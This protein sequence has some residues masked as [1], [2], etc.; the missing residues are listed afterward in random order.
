MRAQP[1]IS[2]V[3]ATLNEGPR[4]EST[5][6][7][8][9]STLPPGSDIVVVDDG[10]ADNSLAFL[11]RSPQGVKRISLEHAGAPRARNAGAAHAAG[12]ILVFSDA[13]MSFPRGWWEP[14]V[15][16][17]EN[18]S[19]AAAAPAVADI[20]DSSCIGYGMSL[21]APDLTAN[22]LL[23]AASRP[24][25]VPI[26]PGACWAMRREVF[27]RTGGF[28]EGILRWGSEDVEFS[29]RL[30]LLGYEL[31]IVPE[32]AV[33]HWFRESG[34]DRPYPVEWSWV[35]HNKLRVAFVHF[36]Q[37]RRWMVARALKKEEGFSAGFQLALNDSLVARRQQLGRL[38]AHDD[39]WFFQKFA[40][41]W[42]QETNLD[43]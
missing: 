8:L 21:P 22:W 40:I 33:G 10:S 7:E 24:Y 38:R 36:S 41:H 35:Q 4:L 25:S 28:D 9:R 1:R 37:A 43:K 11:D 20:D 39:D 26:L 18:G 27:Q 13:H 15:E 12:D 32:V 17:L 23:R 29:I 19:V 3:I 5:V 31:R 16:A 34:E 2:A 14:L 30:W 42:E 6:E